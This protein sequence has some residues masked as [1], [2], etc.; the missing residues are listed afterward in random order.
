MRK[1]REKKRKEERGRRRGIVIE[2]SHKQNPDP[3]RACSRPAEN[4]K[5]IVNDIE[6]WKESGRAAGEVDR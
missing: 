4:A 2:V 3:V 1:R 6:T 5:T